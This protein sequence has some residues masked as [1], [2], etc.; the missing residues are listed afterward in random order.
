[1]RDLI[2]ILLQTMIGMTLMQEEYLD[3]SIALA[4][5]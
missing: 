2:L 4:S 3:N 1:M 5:K